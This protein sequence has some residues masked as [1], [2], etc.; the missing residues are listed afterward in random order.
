M[1]NLEARH[2]EE[3]KDHYIADLTPEILEE[4]IT[5]M[6]TAGEHIDELGLKVIED[7]YERHVEIWMRTE[8][9]SDIE[10]HQIYN[11]KEG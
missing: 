4:T 10:T 8:D 1:R 2:L 6:K 7:L 5:E 9:G 3:N 11:I